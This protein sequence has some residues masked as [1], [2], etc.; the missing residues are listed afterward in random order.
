MLRN[1]IQSAPGDFLA[2]LDILHEDHFFSAVRERYVVTI[3]ADLHGRS[4]GKL[5]FQRV[6]VADGAGHFQAFHVDLVV[7]LYGLDD[8]LFLHKAARGRRQEQNNRQSEHYW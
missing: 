6:L 2:R 8:R 7:E 3:R 4:A 5:R 1:V